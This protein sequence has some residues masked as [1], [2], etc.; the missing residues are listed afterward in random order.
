MKDPCGTNQE[1]IE[2]ISALQQRIKEL[3]HSEAQRKR[4]EETLESERTLL[5]NLI[6]NV[7]DRIYAKDSEGRFIICNEAMIRRMGMTSMAELAGKSDFDFLPL[8]MA[9]RFHADEQ[10]IIQS[11]TPMINR[12]EPLVSE[13][14]TITRWNLATKVPLLDKQGNRIGIVGVGRE[15]TDRKRAEEALRW[16]EIQLHAILESTADGI[17]AV[18]NKG[19]VIKTNRRFVDLWRIP[20]SLIEAGDDHALL[21][22]VMNQL[23]DPDAF[24]KKVRLL[25]ASDT[26]EIDT[27]AFKD[28][29]VFERY[30]FPVIME[31]VI[32]GRVW[33]FG[34]IT[35][36]RRMEEALSDSEERYRRIVEASSDAVLLRS[37]ENIIYANPAA[38]KLFRANHPGDLIG[39]QY[40][41]LVHPD[42]LAISTERVKRTL[43]ENWIAPP[44]EHRLLALDGQVVH[45][46]STGVPV[47]YRGET[48]IFG[49]FRDI[50]ERK[51]A[52]QEK[53]I[54]AGIE[55]L[56]GSTL[57]IEE[58]Y[59]RFA[60]ESKKLIPFDRLVVN[61]NNPQE[62]ECR[63]AYVSGVDIPGRRPGDSK[64]L[65]GSTDE[66][67]LR[68]RSG[69]I[70]QSA[71]VEKMAARFPGVG[72]VLHAEAGLC[73][74]L[75]VPLIYRDEVICAL[76]FWSKKSE[77][78]S[79]RDLHLAERI[80]SQIAGAIANA[81]LYAGLKKMD[82]ELKESEQ[83]Y[84]ELSMVDDLT[85]LFNS[86]HFY[87]QLKS[88]TERSNRYGQPLTL[89]LLDLDNFKA[90]NDAYGH[91]EGDQVLGRL[92]QVVKRCLRETDS[93]Y[94]YGGEEFTILLPMTT[95]GDGVVTAERIRTEFRKE[96]FFPMSGQEVRV[97]VSIGI[98]QYQT[99]E[100]M[101]AFVHRVDQLMYQGKRN[102]KD[103]VCCES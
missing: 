8:E 99:M 14:G 35:E 85:Q 4:A 65:S 77:A 46:E 12:E 71:S 54:L 56:I 13:S 64:S 55:R 67:L 44:R 32:I 21:D 98:G 5:R 70:I 87:V 90:F 88:E 6:D 45:V 27:L 86:R 58:V 20:Q 91:V 15:I 1:L 30:S 17:L 48:H 80:G 31:G 75:S 95:S 11:G 26:V 68:T 73:S 72:T 57:E 74:L 53:A 81:Q 100:E 36:R 60:A 25:Y 43:D 76:H 102:G 52:E 9:Q 10:A 24:L 42:D 2:E 18:D 79:E 16:S 66:L 49:I 29:R 7:P 103:R 34:D 38:L 22:F 41:D 82:R 101:K 61:L 40:L 89:L 19:K 39:K 28:G 33:S 50:T 3:E 62:N 23:S 84:R 51:L 47:K 78:Y 97:T 92:G 37:K 94:R 69:I 83:K 59:E 63:C 96:I 93:A